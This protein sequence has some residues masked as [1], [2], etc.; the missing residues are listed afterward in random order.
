[1][2]A[3]PTGWNLPRPLL[4]V[5]LGAVFVGYGWLKFHD[6]Y[7][8]LKSVHEYG[9]LDGLKLGSMPVENLAAIGVPAL[10]IIGGLLLALGIWRRGAAA[11]LAL[12]LAA[13]T[14][15]VFWRSLDPTVDPEH[16]QW[17]L[18]AFD[19]GCGTGKVIVWQKLTMNAVLLTALV[20]LGLRRDPE[21]QAAP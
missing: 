11:W 13:F 12:F 5:A 21:L 7:A 19:C 8:Y 18:R 16:A 17:W 3:R 4:R 2:S 9:V 20:L 15:M 1:M 10:E 14:A 6:P